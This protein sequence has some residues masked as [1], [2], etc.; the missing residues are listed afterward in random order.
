ML[1]MFFFRKNNDTQKKSEVTHITEN[2]N[3]PSVGP[4]HAKGATRLLLTP[5]LNKVF[6]TKFGPMD[7]QTIEKLYH[8][9]RYQT[10][11]E[12]ASKE[13]TLPMYRVGKIYFAFFV[14][15]YCIN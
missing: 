2:T 1:F 9:R 13:Y 3:L 11:A 7:M 6:Q 15:K 4:R 12:S 10:F 14:Y 8:K 5:P